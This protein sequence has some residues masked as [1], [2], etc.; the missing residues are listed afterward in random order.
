MVLKR[1]KTARLIYEPKNKKYYVDKITNIKEFQDL[2]S[3][4]RDYG[5]ICRAEKNQVE[6]YYKNG[7]LHF[8]FLPNQVVLLAKAVENLKYFIDY[9]KFFN[10]EIEDLKSKSV[11][12]FYLHQILLTEFYN[13]LPKEVQSQAEEK[14]NFQNYRKEG[15]EEKFTEKSNDLVI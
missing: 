13:F 8:E 15:M 6:R 1:K 12:L 11:D 9:S 10:C 2:Q 4:F 3:A 7:Y 14:Y 5:D